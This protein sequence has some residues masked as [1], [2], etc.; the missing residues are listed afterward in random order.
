[1]AA[2][3][4]TAAL[5]RSSTDLVIFAYIDPGAGSLVVQAVIATALAIPF[6]FRSQVRR[7]AGIVR[8][9]LGRH[10]GET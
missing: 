6:F 5:I 7:A 4:Q 10:R 8:G 1:M 3:C 9:I 2:A